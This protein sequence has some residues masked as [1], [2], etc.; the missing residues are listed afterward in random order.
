MISP[1]LF[2]VYA[3]SLHGLICSEVDPPE[4]AVELVPTVIHYQ[5]RQCGNVHPCSCR[6]V[7]CLWH[8]N[9]PKT[10]V[11]RT[12]CWRSNTPGLSLALRGTFGGRR[13]I[14]FN[15]GTLEENVVV[16]VPSIHSVGKISRCYFFK[17]QAEVMLWPPE[18]CTEIRSRVPR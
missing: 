14:E 10:C 8:N 18:F 12:M 11:F 15:M 3:G 13:E 5:S 2:I 17:V 16:K 7:L 1:R 4:D 6:A 9:P